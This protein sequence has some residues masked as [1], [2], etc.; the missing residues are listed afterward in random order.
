MK[1]IKFHDGKYGVM[2]EQR[3]WFFF[4]RIEFAGD[5]YWHTVRDD[6][7]MQDF[8]KVDSIEAARERLRNANKKYEVIE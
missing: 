8:L 2:R 6:Q 7:F 1:I 5:G 4:K 3:I